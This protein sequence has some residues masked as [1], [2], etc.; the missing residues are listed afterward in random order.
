[1]QLTGKQI[2]AEGIITGFDSENAIQQQG[3]DLRIIQINS[4][5]GTGRI[6]KK[7]KTFLPSY[8]KIELRE[9]E[10]DSEVFYWHL[11]PGY[12]EIMFA[13]G[14]KMPNNRAMTL[15]Q[16]SSLL[17]SGAIIRSSQFDAGFETDHM[18]TFMQVFNPI[19]IEYEAR[20]AQTLV[21]ETA[22]VE[23]TYTGQ[24]QKDSQ[25]KL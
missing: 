4:I 17:R 13:E 10:E 19:E 21:M 1:M 22:E 2:A 3:I 16:R 15:V 20:V 12:Y 23:N 25:R 24:F 9:A 6:P 8:K 14:C 7:G 11:E 18:G 5:V